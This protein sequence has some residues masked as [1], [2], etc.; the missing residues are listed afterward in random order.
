[1]ISITNHAKRGGLKTTTY[2]AYNLQFTQGQ[3][4]LFYMALARKDRLLDNQWGRSL[5]LTLCGVSTWSFQHGGFRVTRLL[6]RWLRVLE[7][8]VPR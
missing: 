5:L 4:S 7:A 3:P 1:M 2:L 6:P 8:H